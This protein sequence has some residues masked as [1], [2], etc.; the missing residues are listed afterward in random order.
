[1]EVAVDRGLRWSRSPSSLTSGASDASCTTWS[2]ADYPSVI[3]GTLS[4]RSRRSSTRS[5]RSSSQQRVPKITTLSSSTSWNVASFESP[6]S[7][8]PL[9]N[10]ST[11]HIFKAT[12]WPHLRRWRLSRCRRAWTIFCRRCLRWRRTRRSGWR[13]S[14]SWGNEFRKRFVCEKNF[15]SVQKSI[16]RF[17]SFLGVLV[18]NI[19]IQ[20][21]NVKKLSLIILYWPKISIN[22]KNL[23]SWPNHFIYA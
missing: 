1:M 4:R 15:I 7:V 9:K 21:L 18:L 10:F 3:S 2:M 11:I 12:S 16:Y 17:F 19:I 14:W 5:S 6:A 22:V 23:C 20:I 8:R 13:N